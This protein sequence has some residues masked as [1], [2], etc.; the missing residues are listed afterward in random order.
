MKKK[1]LVCS[2]IRN[3]AHNIP[4]WYQLLNHLNFLLAN[5]YDLYLSVYEND[6][7]DDTKQLLKNADFSKFA[8]YR[9]IS[10]NLGTQQ[11]GSIWSIERLKNLAMYR[12]KC[13]DGFDLNQFEKIA[14]IESDIVY[15]PNWCQE[16]ILAKHPAQVGIVPD[17]YSAW[18]L[19]S[20]TNPK[21]SMYLYDVCATRQTSKDICWNFQNEHNWT[22]NNII[23]TNLG[24]VDGFCLFSLYSTFNCFCVYNVNPFI[25]N[26]IKWNYINPRINASNIQADDNR[27]YWI[28]SDT[29]VICEDFHKH[30]YHNILINKNCLVRHL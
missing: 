29:V 12:Q 3:Q 30:G 18:S 17:V 25:K 27:N 11:F 21:E 8:N 26:N 10:E 19:R 4:T 23:K 6:S 16:L 20:F 15:D 9:L 13:L 24:G 5:Q 2:I 7:L 1:I 22:V 14:Y 28:D